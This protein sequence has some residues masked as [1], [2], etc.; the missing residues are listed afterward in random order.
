VVVSDEWL[1]S[2]KS[3]LGELPLAMQ[4]RF[5]SK[6]G[7][8]V[9]D[10][11]VLT[12][13]K[14]TGLFFDAAV[15]CGA[16]PKRVCNLLTQT[17]LKLANERQT[18]VNTLGVSPENL[19]EIAKM[20]DAGQISAT[21][22]AAIFDEMT[23]SGGDPMQIAEQKNLLQKSDSGEIE[24]LVDQCRPKTRRPFRMPEITPKKRK[25]PSVF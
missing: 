4:Q 7:L 10:A 24:P 3:R 2:I 11:Q 13:E 17:G 9:Y 22:A 20:T 23:R 16:D 8:S 21:S 6:Y 19:A 15:R 1:D 18:T 5:I 12:A 14:A 25:K